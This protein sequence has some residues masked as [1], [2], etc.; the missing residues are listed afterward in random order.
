MSASRG[1]SPASI[2]AAVTAAGA[3]AAG[4]VIV[5]VLDR[6]RRRLAPLDPEEGYDQPPDEVHSVFA[7]DGLR[8]HV[9]V[10]LPRSGTARDGAAPPLTV[11]LAHGFTLTLD[12]WVFQRRALAAAGYRV[13]SWD[14]RGHGLSEESDDA[15]VSIEQLGHDLAAVIEAVV[16]DGDLVL[17]GHSM[18]GMTVMAFAHHHVELLKERVIAVG[19]V[20]TSAGGEDLTSLEFGPWA[21]DVLGRLGPGVLHRLD[22]HAGPLYRL[23]PLGR[24]VE[25]IAVEHYSFRSPVSHRLVRFCGDMIFG[26]RFSTMA[27]FIPAIREHDERAALIG[28]MGIETLVINGRGDVLITP[29]HSDEI[30]RGIPGAEHIV[31]EE[32][33]HLIQLEHPDLVN[34]QLLKLVERG[35]RA[36]VAGSPAPA[37]PRVAR[38]ITDLAR[39]RRVRKA[40]AAVEA[41]AT[42][43]EPLARSS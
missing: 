19:L 21:G 7:S 16:P 22:R 35:A 39:Q 8:L 6:R 15:H 40:R 18:G 29:D 27:Q 12:S 5:E 30:V 24:K 31:V 23:R 14:H 38:A 3:A 10:D 25:D 2:G 26:T 34:H 41:P 11:V 32:A 28:F 20:A 37:R 42:P 43:G 1:P 36:G 33:G 9:E 4:A 17:V 13:V